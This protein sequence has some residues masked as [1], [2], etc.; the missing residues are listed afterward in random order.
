M[1]PANAA[2]SF[3]RAALQQ[4]MWEHVGLLR[5]DAGLADAV[6]TLSAWEAP[7][8]RTPAG[9]EDA[10]LLVVARAVASA[11]LAR[12]DSLG[13]HFRLSA[14]KPAL[15]QPALPQPATTQPALIGAR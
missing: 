1:R 5:D 11:A 2:P 6:R 14:E 3:S 8:P 10:N 15:T 9:Q 12:P 13:A 7:Q 4:L